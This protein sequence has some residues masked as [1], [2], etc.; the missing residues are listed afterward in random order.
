VIAI[1]VTV[2]LISFVAAVA[3]EWRAW[4]RLGFP[5]T[6][7]PLRPSNVGGLA[8]IPTWLADVVVLGT[9]VVAA[10]L[11]VR[12]YRAGATV[13]VAIALGT[14]VLTGTR[15]VLLVIAALVVAAVL[16]AIRNRARRRAVSVAVTGLLAI[17]IVGVV[18]V[19]GS[20]RDLD[21]GRSSAYSSA[22]TRFTESPVLG[23][24]PGTY[25]VERLHDPVDAL[26]HVAFPEAHNF[27]LN[28]LATSGIVGLLGMAGTVVL[29]A[30]AIRASWRRAPAERLIV[31]GA[32]F[33]LTVF[34]AHGMVDVVFALIGMNMLALAVVAIA[35]TSGVP[36]PVSDAPRARSV[37]VGVGLAFLVVVIMSGAVVRTEAIARTVTDADAALLTRPAD[38]LRL[39]RQAT[40]SAPDLVPA[41]WVQMAAADATNDPVGAMA[42]ARKIAELE[43]FGQEWMTV[44]I[45]ASRQGDRTTE[46]G[47]IRRAMAGPP[48]DPIVELN[49]IP[50]LDAAGDHAGA[51]TAARQLLQVQP[52]IEGIIRDSTAG[53]A[54]PVADVRAEVAQQRLAAGDPAAAF[55]IAL[56]GED[57][58]L[59]QDLLAKITSSDPE[60]AT[61]WA[62][63]VDAWF[64]DPKAR[65]TINAKAR[66]QPTLERAM[67]A[68]RIAGRSCDGRGMSFWERAMKI[69]FAVIATTPKRLRRAPIDANRAF[70]NFYP[71]WVWGLDQPKHPYV[72]GTL[73]FSS[74]RPACP[75]AGL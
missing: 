56:S 31:A 43:G 39:A 62:P 15:S 48:I 68:W 40:A 41:W 7:L 70:P 17:G 60:S 26:P 72:A 28:T 55:L 8:R 38:S 34:A 2:T 24:G 74:G 67:W 49:A 20:S 64:G 21:E 35:S 69:R 12:G 54:A 61:S 1:V 75:K 42:A 6:S 50:L 14:I 57:R 73:T 37:R 30:L 52:D 16:V 63:V 47:A 32:L 45:L 25:A 65:D 4:L 44:A 27:V 18:F 23:S 29:V 19:L 5:L 58:G 53:V 51:L 3:I 46:L 33:G 9:P 36:V 11:W 59:S 71:S 10:S 13:F 22:L 66:S